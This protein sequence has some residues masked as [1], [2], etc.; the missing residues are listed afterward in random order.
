MYQA[1]TILY[2]HIHSPCKNT[3]L[4]D[5]MYNPR[6]TT[7]NARFGIASILLL[8]VARVIVAISQVA[9][10]S[11]LIR[12]LASRMH[13]LSILSRLAE[14]GYTEERESTCKRQNESCC[15]I[16]RFIRS[17][18]TKYPKSIVYVAVRKYAKNQYYHH[19]MKTLTHCSRKAVFKADHDRQL[20]STVATRFHYFLKSEPRCHDF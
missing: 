18:S 16:D 11:N 4:T 14:H 20:I 5:G 3:A 6:E 13:Y 7:E 10:H 8:I 12:R 1:L 15:R 19:A 9:H 17:S 2:K